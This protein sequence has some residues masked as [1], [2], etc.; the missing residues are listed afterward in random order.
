MTQWV[1]TWPLGQGVCAVTDGAGRETRG[2]GR[3]SGVPKHGP[4]LGSD[5]DTTLRGQRAGRH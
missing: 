1:T 5:V 4:G 3:V 2:T